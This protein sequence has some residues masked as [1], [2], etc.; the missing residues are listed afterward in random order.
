M[1]DFGDFI[2]K[3]FYTTPIIKHFQNLKN[4][5][6]VYTYSQNSL[7]KDEWHHVAFSYNNDS[8]WLYI[9]GVLNSKVFKGFP[10]LFL[11]TLPVLVGHSGSNVNYEFFNGS[12]D[13]IQIYNCVLSSAQV[14]NL[15]TQSKPNNGN[16]STAINMKVIDGVGILTYPNPTS[17]I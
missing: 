10:S 5:L 16:I 14:K 7:P 6:Q 4:L 15:Y 12:I 9:D 11:P 17:S 3:K 1:K 2:K 13:D 8:L